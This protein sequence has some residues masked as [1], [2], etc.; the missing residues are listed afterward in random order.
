MKDLC[1]AMGIEWHEFLTAKEAT[2]PMECRC[3]RPLTKANHRNPD[4]TDPALCWRALTWLISDRKRF[5]DFL[6][7]AFNSADEGDEM[8]MLSDGTTDNDSTFYDEGFMIWLFSNPA[9]FIKLA[10]GWCREHKEVK[11]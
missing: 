3:G 2:Y 9:E 1:K 6:R 10:N 4:P 7:F 11:P 8:S 5:R